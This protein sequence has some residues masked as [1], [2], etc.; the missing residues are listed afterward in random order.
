MKRIY[1]I[2]L[3]TFLVALFATTGAIAQSNGDFRSAADGDWSATATWETFDGTSWVAAG[4][5]PDGSENIAILD[6]DSVNVATGTVT[7]TG[8]V[9]IESTTPLTGGELTA[10]G[11]TL[12]FADGSTY[13][14]D[15]DGGSVP[16]ADWQ[17]GSTVLFTGILGN[18]PD[19]R[20]QAFHN[21]TWDNPGQI[22]NLSLG[23]GTVTISGTVRVVDTGSSR[24][25]LTSAGDGDGQ[26]ITIEGD[27]LVEGGAVETTGSGDEA[28]YNVVVNGDVVV[29]G[30]TTFATSRGSGGQATWTLNGDFTVLGDA[31]LRDSHDGDMSRIVFAGSTVQNVS[32]SSDAEYN[33]SINYSVASGSEISVVADSTFHYED[34][35]NLEGTLTVSGEIIARDTLTVNGG[36]M[37]VADGGTY[38][39]AHDAGEIPTATWAD[40]STVLLTGIETN[41]PDNGDQDFFNYT[42]DNAGQIEN[43]NIGWD[44]YTLRGSMSVLNTNGNQ[45]RLSSAGDEGD[46]ARSIT[47]MGDVVVDG[48]TSE[49]TATGSGDIFD[50]DVTVMG[51][52]SI[53]NGGFLSVSRGS[54][55]RAVWTLYGD[56][57]INGGEIGDSDIDKHGQT[58][59]FVFAA[60]TASDGVPGQTLT[61]NNVS[62]DSEVYFEITDSSG[63]ALAAGSDFAYEGVFTNYGVFDVDGGATLTFT[64][65]STYDHARDGG[66]FPTATWAEGSTALVSGTVTSAPGNGNQDFYN[67][68]INATGNLEN[69]DLGMM[70][71]TIGGNIDVI[72]TGTARF[73]L[74]NPSSFDTLSITIMGDINMGANAE[75]F[76]SNGTGSGATEINIH[77]HG[78]ITV[79]GGNFSI[80]RG[81]GPI[82][83]WYLYEGDFTFNAGETQNSNARAGSA[84]I[85][86]GEETA[87]HLAVSD[88]VEISHLP[89]LVQDGA[90]LDMGTSNLSESGDNFT[91]E[92]GGTLASSDSAAFSAA[93]GGNLELGGSGDNQLTLSSEAH[94]VINGSEAQWTGFSLPLQVASLTID[95]EAGVTQSRGVTI[96]EY[97]TLAAGVFDNTIGFTL[98]EGATVNYEGGS[99]IIPVGGPSIGAFALTSPESGFELDLTGDASTE[100]TISWE[101]PTAPDSVTYTWHADSVGGDFSDPLVSIPADDEGSATTLTLTY[102]AIDDVIAGLGVAEGEEIDLIWSVTAEAGITTR[103]AESSFDLSITR[104][105]GVS[106][107][108]EDQIPTEFALKQNYPNPFN[109]T[110]T[111]SYDIPEASE[112]SIEIFDVTGRKVTELVNAR[113]SPGTYEIQWN[114]AQFATGIYIYR[115]TAGNYSAVRKL[116]LIK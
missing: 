13:Q 43:I 2:I 83:N 22:S 7:I 40:G 101:E 87:Q 113:Q 23:L 20:D 66:D 74:S 73:Y 89:I 6:G 116:T 79:D 45:F 60:D 37:T 64:D 62:Y 5:A 94:Y 42:W 59:S 86:A 46:P 55:G 97:L 63:V 76:A 10:D 11:G 52:I 28:T 61:A 100:V 95:N 105:L 44:D 34:D 35:F 26:T 41:D 114:A 103:F 30:G 17:T 12:V 47:I 91:L 65:E 111:I 109:P 106:N 1:T 29:S 49:F 4:A 75:A 18:G 77:H 25:R 39:H 24:F 27:F 96:N 72:S 88:E 102:Q 110:T 32:I 56:M 19:N 48:E 38:N 14:H 104:N 54:G 81:S 58:R 53:T 50:Y 33:G 90:Y 107:E 93:D 15:R 51:D 68:V 78:N 82:V 99:L 84:F 71:N 21:I 67:L 8:Q 112:V 36:T 9:T 3:T 16:E 80:S 69:N 92:A 70:D 108:V 31:E 115:I 57:T 85:F 98:A